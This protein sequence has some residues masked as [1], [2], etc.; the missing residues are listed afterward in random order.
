MDYIPLMTSPTELGMLLTYPP[1]NQQVSTTFTDNP[2]ALTI[3]LY[4]CFLTQ[5]MDHLQW[6]LKRHDVERTNLFTHLLNNRTFEDS[7]QPI[8]EEFRQRT[9]WNEPYNQRPEPP[10][11][12]SNPRSEELLMSDAPTPPEDIPLPMSLSPMSR[13]YHTPSP[14]IAAQ[15]PV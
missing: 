11:T 10:R 12:P 13:R 4:Y 3:L 9:R 7:L 2:T 1:L 6:N 14:S 5:N 15:L 8:L